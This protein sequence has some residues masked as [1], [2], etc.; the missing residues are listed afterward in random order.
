VPLRLDGPLLSF[1]WGCDEHKGGKPSLSTTDDHRCA[2][3]T[4]P[5]PP[6]TAA[7]AILVGRNFQLHEK[8]PVRRLESWGSRQPVGTSSSVIHASTIKLSDRPG[9]AIKKKH[10]AKVPPRP[11]CK[12]H[13]MSQ[14]ETSTSKVGRLSCPGGM[15]ATAKAQRVAD[16]TTHVPLQ[17]PNEGDHYQN[18]CRIHRPSAGDTHRIVWLQKC[19][20]LRLW[21]YASTGAN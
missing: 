18:K 15:K 16:S 3:D 11:Q 13:A 7:A 12:L 8:M 2:R 21:S 14:T 17:Q 20:L 19:S 4:H 1:L 10:S 9:R 5:A 6:L